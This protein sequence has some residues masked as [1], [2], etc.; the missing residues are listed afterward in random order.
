MTQRTLLVSR[1]EVRLTRL[2]YLGLND[3]PVGGGFEVFD[4]DPVTYSDKRAALRA[5]AAASRRRGLTASN[6]PRP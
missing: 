4:E 6:T 3:I 2:T 5:F 1:G